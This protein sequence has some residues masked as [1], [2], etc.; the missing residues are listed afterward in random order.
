MGV[1]RYICKIGKMDGMPDSAA[2]VLAPPSR[3]RYPAEVGAG[4]SG[5]TRDSLSRSTPE[6]ESLGVSYF[7][8]QRM[9]VECL[10]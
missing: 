4:I 9:F 3:L 1:G 5:E 10:L 7:L 6:L 8:S 2:Q